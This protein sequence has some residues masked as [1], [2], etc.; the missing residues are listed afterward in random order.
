M[1]VSESIL[2]IYFGLCVECVNIF[3]I[4]GTYCQQREVEAITE[5]MADDEG[6]FFCIFCVIYKSLAA[7]LNNT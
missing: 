1:T 3:L 4:T 2:Y 6:N 7:F 5:G